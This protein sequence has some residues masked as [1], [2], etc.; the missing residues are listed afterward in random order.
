MSAIYRLRLDLESEGTIRIQTAPLLPLIG[1]QKVA[2]ASNILENYRAVQSSDLLLQHK[3]TRRQ[4]Y[5]TAWKKAEAL[6]CFDAIFTNEHGY[7]T[8]GGRTNLFIKLN[9]HWFTPP[10]I[11]GCLAGVMRSHLLK[12]PH[13]KTSERS[14]T[15]DDL[16]HAEE[17]LLCN[18]LR[19]MIPVIIES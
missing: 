3:V 2:L 7:L 17:I 6:G 18:A 11:D 19:G 4:L 9:G 8:E 16:M 1:Q 5:D 15:L 14:L 10:L 12:N 13:M